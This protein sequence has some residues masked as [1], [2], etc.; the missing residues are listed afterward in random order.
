MPSHA[1]PW[2]I[3][4]FVLLGAALLTLWQRRG[5]LEV[6][7]PGLFLARLQAPFTRAA[8]RLEGF[9]LSFQGWRELPEENR[10]LRQR[11]AHAEARAQAQAA[12]SEENR[13]LTALLGLRAS[14][15]PA[16]LAARV[17]ARDPMSWHAQVV[18]DK[19]SLDGVEQDRVAVAPE[20]LVGR[21]S[22]VG[23][24]SCRVR[25]ILDRQAAVPA[26]LVRSGALGVVYGEDGFNC[27]MKYLSHDVQVQE[28]EWVVTS[29]LGEV[30]PPNLPLGRVSRQYGRTEA[31]FQ[32]VQVRPAVDF[33]RL[34][35]ALIVEKAR[36]G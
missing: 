21:V 16:G 17:A 18:L 15:W 23:S 29:G 20:G 36:G 19:G 13:R 12:I 25:L 35:E 1:S 5:A 3:V 8:G 10:R 30:Y 26:R 22:A 7:A 6:D 27:V 11:L 28:G 9:C 2:R 24:R 34:Q 4:A 32:S 33:G 31:L 14:S